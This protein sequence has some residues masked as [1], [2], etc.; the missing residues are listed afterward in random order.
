M[1]TPLQIFSYNIRYNNP[2]DGANAWP[3]RQARVAALLQAYQPDLIGLQEVRHEQLTALATALP[4][5]NWLGV[6]RDDGV[7]AGEYAPIF[8]RRER[9]AQQE[10]GHFWLSETPDQ[11]GSF[12][13]DAACVRIATW[14]I[15]TDNRTGAQFLHLNTHLDHRGLRAQLESVKLL[16]AFL[17]DQ[18]PTMPAIITGDFNCA[19]DSETYQALIAPSPSTGAIFA[20]AMAQSVTPHEGPTA[21]FTTD[22]AD[23][24]QEKIDYI[25][26]YA[27]KAGSDHFTVTRHAIL[28]DQADGCYPSDHLPVLAE[29]AWQG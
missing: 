9:L 2:A 5:Y 11:V 20:D 28:T 25:F 19:P 22:F 12:G 24:L 23:P 18:A 7:A 21:T 17:V 8:Y 3:Q 16:Q 13:W 14:A 15:F 26:L 27:G 29:L 4:A 1:A 6:G 10:Y